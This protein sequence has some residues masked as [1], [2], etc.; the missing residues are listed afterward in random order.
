MLKV[1]FANDTTEKT[2]KACL[3]KW[4]NKEAFGLDDNLRTAWHRNLASYYSNI[5][6]FTDEDSGIG[7]LGSQGEYVDVKINHARKDTRDFITLTTKQRLAFDVSADTTDSQN[8]DEARMATA[9]A[10]HIVESKQLDLR[11]EEMAEHAYLTG[12]GFVEAEWRTDMGKE[13]SADPTTGQVL[14]SGDL[15]VTN[16]TVFDIRWDCRK[17]FQEAQWCIVRCTRN[18]WDLAA[19]YPEMA[20]KIINSND[21]NIEYDGL[22]MDDDEVVVYKFYHTLT[23]AVPNG[24]LIHFLTADC[25][26]FDSTNDQGEFHNPYGCI[27]IV[28]M[29]PEPVAKTGFGFPLYS[30]LL[31]AQEMFD[32]SISTIATNQSAFGVQQLTAPEG[33]DI[34]PVDLGGGLTIHYYKPQ[35]G[36][37]DAGKP[38]ALELLK[39]PPEMFKSLDIYENSMNKLSGMTST[40]RG[41]PPAGV[42]AAQA[43]VSL[44]TNAIEAS[45]GFTKAYTLAVEKFMLICIKMYQTFA[46]VPQLVPMV[47][48]QNQYIVKSFTGDQIK[49]ISRVS[50]KTTNPIAKTAAGRFQLADTMLNA[51]MVKSPQKY[52]EMIDTGNVKVLYENEVNEAIQIQTENEDILE[53][54]VV[55]AISID[56]HPAHIVEHKAIAS[57]PEIRRM[58]NSV[59]TDA[60]GNPLPDTP[61]ETLKAYM[62]LK[63]TLDHILEHDRLL[64]ETDPQL[65]AVAATG[66]VPQIQGPQ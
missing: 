21:P 61:S 51:G 41:N 12:I 31:P 44:S 7:S 8:L 23:P 1:Y 18:R 65:Q 47:G 58:A 50:M 53:G 38:A 49:N 48:K 9:L 4:E 57:N 63:N 13:Y 52:G 10:D 35:P 14:K 39:T 64:K 60:Q 5:F 43:I 6:E 40:L 56:N 33:S 2:V 45:Q 25:I 55:H 16:P 66:K 29:V 30:L 36:I 46:S 26:L 34:T 37:P 15:C 24:R 27:P 62:V 19:E 17:Q 28:S 32:V 11:T 42:T 54:K 3:D 59:I 22:K 20:D